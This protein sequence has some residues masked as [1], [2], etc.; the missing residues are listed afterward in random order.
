[1]TTSEFDAIT[2]AENLYRTD[3]SSAEWLGVAA[4]SLHA[5][6]RSGA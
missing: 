2:A 3:L 4:T 1:V 5:A 6:V